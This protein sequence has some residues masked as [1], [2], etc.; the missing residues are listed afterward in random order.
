MDLI[1]EAFTKFHN[2]EHIEK[3]ADKYDDINKLVKLDDRTTM[4]K[5]N[6][7]LLKRLREE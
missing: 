1:K 2:R 4:D 7:L 3:W 6:D 5:I